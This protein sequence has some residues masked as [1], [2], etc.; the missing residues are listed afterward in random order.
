MAEVRNG[1]D[2][3]A[4]V[5]LRAAFEE[6]DNGL[7]D[8]TT[9]GKKETAGPRLKKALELFQQ[10][11]AEAPKDSSQALGAAIGVA[12]TLEARNELPEAIKQYKLVAL[13]WAGTAEAKCA[14]FLGA[15]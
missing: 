13:K 4:V 7:V 12:R 8:L 5:V 2:A 15:R 9:P 3:G 1:A 10:V 6:Y 11:A 14:P